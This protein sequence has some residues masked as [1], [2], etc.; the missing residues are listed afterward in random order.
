MA[1]QSEAFSQIQHSFIRDKTLSAEARMV[2]IIYASFADF[3][4]QTWPS[5]ATLRSITGFGINKLHRIR[6]ELVEKGVL[7]RRQGQ[8]AFGR[9]DRAVYTVADA[10]LRRRKRQPANGFSEPMKARLIAYQHLRKTQQKPANGIRESAK[11]QCF[12]G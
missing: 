8:G 10:V 5:F 3:K 12:T 4:G 6:Q 7:V 2:A 1:N 9:F 11:T